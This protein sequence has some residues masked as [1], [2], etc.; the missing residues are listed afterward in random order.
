MGYVLCRHEALCTRLLRHVGHLLPWLLR[1]IALISLIDARQVVGHRSL[2]LFGAIVI[3]LIAVCVLRGKGRL[4]VIRV[5]ALT[6]AMCIEEILCVHVQVVAGCHGQC[7]LVFL[8]LAHVHVWLG[9]NA[10]SLNALIRERAIE[11]VTAISHHVCL[12]TTHQDWRLVSIDES[13]DRLI[14]LGCEVI[15]EY[16][17]P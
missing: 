11:V 2:N 10:S 5:H 14:R 13:V 1:L 12:L 15:V 8:Q 3:R 17:P 9:R 16:A 4:A 6:P 7:R